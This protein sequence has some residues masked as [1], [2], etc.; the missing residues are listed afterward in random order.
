MRHKVL[1]LGSL[2]EFTE[3]VQMA[4]KKGY[5]TVV[6]DGIRMDLQ[7]NMRTDLM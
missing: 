3:L 1:I 5:E 4:G 6:C 2:G 7:E